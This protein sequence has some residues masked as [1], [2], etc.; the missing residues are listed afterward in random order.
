MDNTISIEISRDWVPLQG[1]ENGVNLQ[2]ASGASVYYT[3]STLPPPARTGGFKLLPSTEPAKLNGGK[4]WVR[5]AGTSSISYTPIDVGAQS[6]AESIGDLTDLPTVN[7]TSLVASIVELEATTVKTSELGVT[8]GLDLL[9]VY[10]GA[11]S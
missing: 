2:R 3:Y 8:E 4:I 6:P 9:A 10:I 5:S 1:V 11:K 7:K